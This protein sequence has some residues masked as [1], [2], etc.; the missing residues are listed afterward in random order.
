MTQK[1]RQERSRQEIFRA[2]M[3]EFGTRG[4]G[5]VTMER[6]CSGHGISKGMM[7][8]YY[9]NKDELFL[10]CVA[11][12]FDALEAYIRQ[13]S[14]NA[15]GQSAFD[16]IKDYFLL[17]ERFFEGQP[18]RKRVFETAIL[19]PP[20]HLAEQIQQLHRPIM[21][22]NR[23]FIEGIVARMTL[24]KDL[25]PQCVAWYLESIEPVIPS[26]IQRF[27]EKQSSRDL[28]AMLEATRKMLDL[29]LLGVARQPAEEKTAEKGC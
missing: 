23:R 25:D 5:E 4:Y 12:T 3:E 24:R 28:H 20:K 7:Y 1:E 11:D 9:S 10:L 14:V 27:L 2:A 8:H 15:E 29:I 17:R 6:I 26:V 21:E 18:Q 16:A 22:L 19:H 13:E